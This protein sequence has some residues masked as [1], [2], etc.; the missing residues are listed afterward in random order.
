MQVYLSLVIFLLTAALPA[1]TIVERHGA[2]SVRGN[3]I[4]DECGRPTQLKG[5]SYFWSQF[6]GKEYWTEEAVKWLRDDWHVT[7]VRAP[8]GVGYGEDYRADTAATLAQLRPVIDGAIEHGLY[9]LIDWHA[10]ENYQDNAREFFRK[11]A[12][13]YGQYPNVIYE[14]WNEP[15]GEPD[16]GEEKWAEIKRYAQDLIAVIREHDPDN[17]IIV[18]TPFYSQLVDVA[19]ADPISQDSLG[20]PVS[21]IAYTLHFYAGAHRDSLRERATRAYDMGLPLMVTESGRVGTDYGPDN[22]LDSA[23]WDRWEAWMDERH[24]SYT[25][26]SLSTKDERSSSL[27]PTAS[28]TGGWTSENLTPEGQ[29]NRAHFRE[30]NAELPAPCGE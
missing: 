20:Q 8:V 11:M 1:Q 16:A 30:V 10:H 19:A 12:R 23:E 6:Q 17:L 27:L 3:Q 25:K 9:A 29:W 18:G 14:L 5:M 28:P 2:L 13:E 26:W 24:I 15:I 22:S 7:L 21:N 4:V